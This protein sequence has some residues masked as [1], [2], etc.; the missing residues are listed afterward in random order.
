MR[1]ASVSCCF[2]VSQSSASLSLCVRRFSDGLLGG[3]RVVSSCAMLHGGQR[4]G[5]LGSAASYCARVPTAIIRSNPLCTIQLQVGGW[6]NQ[7]EYSAP[8]RRT[9]KDVPACGGILAL[10]RSLSASRIK[11]EQPTVDRAAPARTMQYTNA[12][13]I[14]LSA[15]D[16]RPD[17]DRPTNATGAHAHRPAT[18]ARCRRASRDR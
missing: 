13:T 15:D 6:L 12:P 8:S 1:C 3:T 14:E 11:L 17:R 4:R 9:A 2:Q 16:G 7:S 10:P 18:R 5:M